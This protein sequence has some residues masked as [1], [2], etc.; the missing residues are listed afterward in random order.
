MNEKMRF[1]PHFLKI[2]MKKERQDEKK[3]K[4]THVYITTRDSDA[5]EGDRRAIEW[6]STDSL[7]VGYLRGLCSTRA[8]ERAIE[9]T[10]ARTFSFFDPL[11]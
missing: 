9:R 1:I 5:R 6:A 8:I 4:G 3:R 11:S 2:R 7:L 10:R